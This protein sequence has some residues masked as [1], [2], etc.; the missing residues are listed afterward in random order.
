MNRTADEQLIYDALSQVVTPP[1]EIE[2]AVRLRLAAEGDRR[3]RALPR[4]TLLLAAAL[5]LFLII[6]AAAA[7]VSGLWQHFWPGADIPYRAVT[8]P[9]VS[10]T[11]GDY[12]LTLEDVMADDSGIILLLSL[13][14]ADGG[15]IDPDARLS[16]HTVH[17]SLL[18]DG[19]S[20]GGGGM[21]NPVL[22][23]DGTALFFCCQLEDHRLSAGETLSGKQLTFTADGVAI[24][25]YS[26]NALGY[27]PEEAVSLAPLA[28]LDIPEYDAGQD[29]ADLAHTSIP[30]PLDEKFP[31]YRILGAAVTEN[32]PGIL[33]SGGTAQSGD[34]VCGG[35][36]P[37]ALVDTRTGETYS[38]FGGDGVTLS[39]GTRGVFYTFRDCPLTAADL[40]WL[41]LVISYQMD[42]VLSD[43]PFSLAFTA[44]RSAALTLDI[45][46][47]VDLNGTALQLT[48]LRLSALDVSFTADNGI[49]DLSTLSDHGIAPVLTMADGSQIATV[50]QGG[51]GSTNGPSSAHFQPVG[52]DGNRIFPDTADI[53]AVSL[54]GQTVWTAP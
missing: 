2:P 23:E 50:W 30:L 48:G 45:Q 40:P 34:L 32:G 15:P 51:S 28:E 35:V 21:D 3:P 9:G 10:Q 53:V 16:G 36:L 19:Q 14:R 12:T 8:S 47:A 20:F 42:K 6:G 46:T 17:A 18:A 43:A 37:E 11:A 1:C 24:P 4:R 39:D 5:A 29:A 41:E 7:G 27:Q 13:S 25:L 38:L 44:D 31:Q 52:D 54:A 26:D 22:S 33:L 49:G